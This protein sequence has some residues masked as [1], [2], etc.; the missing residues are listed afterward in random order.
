FGFEKSAEETLRGTMCNAV[1]ETMKSHNRF[2]S[3]EP[4]TGKREYYAAIMAHSLA[5]RESMFS[6]F[7]FLSD[8]YA[9]NLRGAI[10]KGD[11]ALAAMPDEMQRLFEDCPE[12][13]GAAVLKGR[14]SGLLT[15]LAVLLRK[16]PI[17]FRNFAGDILEKLDRLYSGGRIENRTY[18]DELLNCWFHKKTSVPAG[19]LRAAKLPIAMEYGDIRPFYEVANSGAVELVIPDFRLKRESSRSPDVFAEI[20]CGGGFSREPLGI[21]G[22]EFSWS[23]EGRRISLFAMSDFASRKDLR[24]RVKILMDGRTVYDSKTSLFREVIAF[25]G[26][27]ELPVQNIGTG[28]FSFFT[29]GDRELSFER[30]GDDRIVSSASGQMRAVKFSERFGLILDGHIVCSDFKDESVEILI[31]PNPSDEVTYLSGGGEYKVYS[32][33]VSV[34][35]RVPKEHDLGRYAFRVN[36]RIYP[37]RESGAGGPDGTVNCVID[38]ADD[39]I[40][41]GFLDIVVADTERTAEEVCRFC[42]YVIK[43]LRIAFDRPYYFGGADGTARIEHNGGQ[44]EFGVGEG[45]YKLIPFGDG[46][47]KIKIPIAAWRMEPPLP[48]GETSESGMTVWRGNITEE[49]RVVVV[50]PEK[51]TCKLRIGEQIIECAK[52]ERGSAVF[53]IGAYA[54]HSDFT[55]DEDVI[56]V[57]LLLDGE[58]DSSCHDLFSIC[59]RETFGEN[60][61][62]EMRDGTLTLKNPAAFIGPDDAKLEYLF[63][64][65][66]SGTYEISAL[67]TVISNRCELPH[68]NYHYKVF[69]L[70]DGLFQAERKMIRTGS[71]ILGDVDIFHFDNKLLEI[72]RVRA[73][74]KEFF[75]LPIYVENLEFAE[76]KERYDDGVAYPVYSGTCYYLNRDDQ[77]IYFADSFNPVQVVIINGRDICLYKQDGSKPYLIYESRHKIIEALPENVSGLISYVPDFYEYEALEGH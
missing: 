68:G 1:Y 70:S 19:S 7:D 62:F 30:S 29:T 36:G 18:L 38:A 26:Y 75:I 54:A 60:P 21:Y 67:E 63:K 53:D 23:A 16:R 22:D 45:E 25:K 71:C 59:L 43:D 69:S 15:G 65:R 9:N 76:T 64:G 14:Y 66:K 12:D 41:D 17:F 6:F 32:G 24:I 49:A 34:T 47:L 4:K 27:G 8:F 37:F 74:F 51:I 48:D 77:K 40:R 11:P 56:P 31:S 3:I 39:M 57:Q 5:P 72:K 61:R 33:D 13:P 52:R 10:V 73:G 58:Y 20:V 50:C 28:I 35:A 2:F 55:R 46:D 44:T 42:C